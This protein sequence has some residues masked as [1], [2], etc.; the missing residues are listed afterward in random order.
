MSYKIVLFSVILCSISHGF[1]VQCQTIDIP[2]MDVRDSMLLYM[3]KYASIH[4]EEC[5]FTKEIQ[6]HIVV[7][8]YVGTLGNTYVSFEIRPYNERQIYLQSIIWRKMDWCYTIYEGIQYIFLFN[9]SSFFEKSNELGIR[10]SSTIG[11]EYEY[12][13]IEC[14][15]YLPFST[16]DVFSYPDCVIHFKGQCIDI[17]NMEKLIVSK[18][19]VHYRY[20]LKSNVIQKVNQEIFLNDSIAPELRFK[21]NST[22]IMIE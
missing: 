13:P 1:M 14:N 16:L 22:K 21:T 7:D 15:Y 5:D 20:P 3:M 2:K 6:S 11:V 18:N 8:R 17:A 19:K 9:D 10:I 12:M 4:F